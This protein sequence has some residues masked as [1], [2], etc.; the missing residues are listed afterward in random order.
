[1][2]AALNR[3]T[4]R[5]INALAEELLADPR[6]ALSVAGD[7]KTREFYAPFLRT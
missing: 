1:M 6:R 2:L 7:V 4:V 3:L 5:D